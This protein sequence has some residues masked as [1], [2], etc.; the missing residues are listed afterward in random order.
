MK[1]KTLK[2]GP[3]LYKKGATKVKYKVSGLMKNKTYY[4]RVRSCRI[5]GGTR[6]KGRWVGGTTQYG[7][8]ST[9]KKVK[10]K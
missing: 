1:K 8:W 9:I 4:V 3:M 6:I 7:N 2:Y 5:V 10:T